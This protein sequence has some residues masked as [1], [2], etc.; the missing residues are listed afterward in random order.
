MLVMVLKSLSIQNDIG[1]A[2][3]EYPLAVGGF[4]R[5]VSCRY[6]SRPL[7]SAW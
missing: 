2:S 3:E 4:T 5:A 1:S 6:I 7:A